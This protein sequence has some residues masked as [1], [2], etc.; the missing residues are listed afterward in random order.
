[1]ARILRSLLAW[2]QQIAL[3]AIKIRTKA[4]LGKI[5]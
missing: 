2:F 1:M 3:A 5:A 4:N